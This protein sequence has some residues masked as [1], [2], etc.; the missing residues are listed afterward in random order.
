MK[1]NPFSRQR[2]GRTGLWLWLVATALVLPLAA[3]ASVAVENSRI[4]RAPDHT[5][6]VLD[7]AG[8]VEHR[9]FS[10]ENPDRLVVDISN[11]RLNTRFD[12]LD[13]D[14]SPISGVR[15]APRDKTDL[16]IVLDLNAPVRPRSF[17]LGRNEQYGDR[18]VIDLYDIGRVVEKTVED[19]V[20]DGGRDI[21]IAIDAGHGGEDPGAIGP[22]GLYEKDVVLAISKK[23]KRLLD[24]EQGYSAVMVRTGDYYVP[25]QNRPQQARQH[26]AD[27]MISVHAD[28]FKNPRARGASV[29]A[30][31]RT[32]AT[33]ETASYLAE[34]ENRADLI[35]GTGDVKLADKDQVLA[36]VLLDL[37]MTATLATSLEVGDEVLRAMGSFAHLH[38]RNVE[39]AGFVVLK[40]PDIPSILVE[41]GF[42][43]NPEESR[44][45]ADS[46][47]QDRI[48]KAIFSG[49]RNYFT[50]RPPEGSWVATQRHGRPGEHVIVRGDTLSGIAERYNISV[51]DLIAHNGLPTT[52][53]EVG[54]RLKIP[55]S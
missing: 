40:S 32:G 22:G 2:I 26:R 33:S 19:V 29:F 23:L 17:L 30:L 15:S 39:Q 1:N 45:L 52:R 25:L 31:S 55:S 38:K 13:L 41:T 37:S 14:S 24:A 21:V 6:L 12:R 11:A 20:T 36:G 44:K 46:A 53:I 10:L 27:L 5:R 47:Y 43:S 42:I 3:G 9:I 18:L 7:L 35:G 34:R 8:P 54:Q 50:R 48:A 16:R 51:N 49:V 28:A 4:W